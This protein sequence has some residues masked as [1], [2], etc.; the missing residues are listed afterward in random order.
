MPVDG[1]ALLNNAALVL[2]QADDFRKANQVFKN[3]EYVQERVVAFLP[4]ALAAKTTLS[5]IYVNHVRSLRKE[6]DWEEAVAVTKK[7]GQLWSGDGQQLAGVALEFFELSTVSPAAF[8]EKLRKVTVDTLHEAIDS[9]YIPTGGTE[10]ELELAEVLHWQEA[11][12][13]KKRWSH[14]QIFLPTQ[15]EL[16]SVLL[17]CDEFVGLSPKPYCAIQQKN[18]S[19]H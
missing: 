11:E 4:E 12:T 10:K 2:T 1:A 7:R 18:Q 8:Q 15:V 9:G 13:L 6:A 17:G 3:A 16:V 5:R 19:W 14:E